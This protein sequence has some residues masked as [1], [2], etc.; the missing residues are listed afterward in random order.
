MNTE[1]RIEQCLK[2]APKPSVPDGLLSKLQKDITPGRI[3]T[4]PSLLHKWLAP[5]G[6]PISAWRVAA[7][8]TIAVMVLLPLTYA[9]GKVIKTY[10]L[11]ETIVVVEEVRTDDGSVTKIGT[12]SVVTVAPDEQ[13]NEEEKLEMEELKQAGKFEKEFVKE[14]SDKGMTFRLYKVSYTLS[15]GKVVTRNEIEGGSGN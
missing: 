7:V 13:I 1:K 11:K 3:Q 6:G 14:W 10:V 2:A 5:T 12:L 15:S 9:G 8:A 4:R